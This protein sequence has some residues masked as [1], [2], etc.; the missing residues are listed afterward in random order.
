MSNRIWNEPTLKPNTFM[1]ADGGNG[2]GLWGMPNL[3]PS[4]FMNADGGDGAGLWGMPTVPAGAFNS[5]E[6]RI[7]IVHPSGVSSDDSEGRVRIVRPSGVSDCGALVSRYQE[8]HNTFANTTDSNAKD[9]LSGQMR[10]VLNEMHRAGCGSKGSASFTGCGTSIANAPTGSPDLSSKCAGGLYYTWC[11]GAFA[12]RTCQSSPYTGG[13]TC[14]WNNPSGGALCAIG[15]ASMVQ[16]SPVGNPSTLPI[17]NNNVPAC[18]STVCMP[19]PVLCSTKTNVLNTST[20][21]GNNNGKT[22]TTTS[23][24]PA[25]AAPVVPA[26]PATPAPM[27]YVRPT[28]WQWLSRGMKA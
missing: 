9:A 3:K 16:S 26:A 11:S 8:L 13:K 21:M 25:A 24:V 4:A 2:A 27:P 6:G 28:F 10:A 1:N 5:N 20:P 7:R 14:A 15:A 22:N 12:P 19:S 17:V 23:C 18:T